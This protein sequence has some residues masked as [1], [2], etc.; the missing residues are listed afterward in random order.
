M[1]IKPQRPSIR[2]FTLVEIMIA[3]GVFVLAITMVLSIFIFCLRSFTAMSNYVILD[4]ENRQTM[5]RLTKEIREAQ[6]V[7][8]H[9]TTPPSLTIRSGSDTDVTYTF[10]DNAKSM[11]RTENGVQR[12]LLTDCSLLNFKLSQRTP[13]EGSYE[14]YDV[15]SNNFQGSA[16][17]VELTW[18]T[19]RAI[20][21]TTLTNSE[22]IQTARIVIRNQ[23]KF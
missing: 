5:D 17:V 8:S 2:G 23:Q 21:G 14:V 22:N 11:L 19:R 7:K 4:I 16:K 3:T 15:A 12:V 9:T 13:I 20:G 18:K 6:Y 1:F 10:D